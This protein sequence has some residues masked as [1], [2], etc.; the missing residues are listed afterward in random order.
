M[1]G[2]DEMIDDIVQSAQKSAA[3]MID[4][5][6]AESAAALEELR[7]RLDAEKSRTDAEAKAAAD[8]AYSGRVKLGELEAGKIMLRAK[9]DCVAAV[10]ERVRDMIIAMPQAEYLKLFTRL[11]SGVAEDGDEVV[12]GKDDKRVTAD[13]VKKLGAATK[14]KLTLSKEKGEFAAGVVLKNARYDRDFTV[15]AIVADLRERTV[16]DVVRALGL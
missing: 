9:Q 16:S 7:D 14:V 8:A 4:E 2:K 10:Y 12:A 15:D 1:Q 6:T 13:F 5:A 11:L 3:A